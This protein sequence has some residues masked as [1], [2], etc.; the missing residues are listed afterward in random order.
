VLARKC[1][2]QRF[3]PDGRFR[4]LME[5]FRQMT[6]E[7]IRLG[8]DENKTSMKTLSLICYPK[9]KRYEIP[10]VYK[11]CAISKAAGILANYRKLSKKHHV[12]EPYCVKPMLITCYG[13]KKTADKLRLP[14]GLQIALN[15]YTQRFLSQPEVEIRSVTLT[16]DCMSI[17]VT[18]QV[19]P[20]ECVGMVG[21]D[22]NLGNVT[23]ADMENQVE[24]YDLTK[25]CSIKARCRETKRRFRRNDA[26]VR[27]QVFRKYGR[28]ERDHVNWLLHN[29]SANIVL[30]AKLRRQT[31]VM[32]NLTGIRK[33]YRRGNGQGREYRSR[34][35]SWSYAEL[36]RQ[37]H[38][39]AIGMQSPSSTLSRM[40]PRRSV[41]YVGTACCLKRTESCT[42]PPAG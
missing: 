34:M 31:I 16:L 17:S 37:I 18:K 24:K 1:V 13:L 38:Y 3:N 27:R 7:C 2:K 19:R 32:E 26:R 12:S 8:T 33:L 4:C 42:V 14:S 21:I 41:R 28:L 23:L 11:L 40:G 22:R 29:V 25:S 5:A 36:Q 10:S 9:L 6:D 39:K 15:A 20:I 35:N 30:N